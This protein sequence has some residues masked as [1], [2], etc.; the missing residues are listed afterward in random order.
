MTAAKLYSVAQEP[1][2]EDA[3][4]VPAMSVR[5]R[6]L[7]IEPTPMLL[8]AI[9]SQS[10]GRS[11]M[12]WER[13][14]RLSVTLRR[15]PAASPQTSWQVRRRGHALKLALPMLAVHDACG[16]LIKLATH[17]STWLRGSK[18]QATCQFGYSGAK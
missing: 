17:G 7:R 11:S 4:S 13:C 18:M 8:R 1:C 14:V 9:A 6:S 3:E 2:Q 15:L 16:E 12:L 10:D 5:A